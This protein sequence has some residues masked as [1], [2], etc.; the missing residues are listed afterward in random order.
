MNIVIVAGGLG[1][2]FKSLS[3]IPKLLLPLHNEDSIITHDCKIFNN[4]NITVL[5]NSKFYNMFVNYINVNNLTNVNVISTSNCNGSYNTIK[6]VYD[7]LPQNDVLFVWSDLILTNSFQKFDT[8]TNSVFTYDAGKYRYKFTTGKVEQVTDTYDGNVP[9]IYYIKKLDEVFTEKVDANQNYDLIDAIAKVQTS[10]VETKLD[11]VLTEFRDL[12]TY[13]DLMHNS[14]S[15]NTSKTRFF[16]EIK[17]D[18]TDNSM[19]I[20]TAIDD[21]YVNIIQKE[22]GWYNSLK[23]LHMVNNIVPKTDDV[24]LSERSFRMEY[25][26]NYITL[27]EFRKTINDESKIVKVYSTIFNYLDNLS[28]YSIHVSLNTFKEDLKKELVDKVIARCD[29]IKDML[30]NYDKAKMSMLLTKVYTTICDIYKNDKFVTYSFCHGDLN[31]SNIL[32]NAETLDV[33]FID[34]RG[35]FGNTKLY[36]WMQYEYAKLRYSLNGYDDFNV[37]PQVYTVDEPSLNNIVNKQNII[38][39]KLS[40]T[41]LKLLVGV[42]Y[43]ALAGYISQDICKANIAYEYGMKLLEN[44]IF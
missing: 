23:Q 26:Q 29:K 6:S 11:N 15:N 8:S 21:N 4:A 41:Q 20:K 10:F 12:E 24:M 25:L 19:L 22:F 32:I 18:E 16:N 27:N 37:Q 7:K 38:N 44:E 34:P 43:I 17:H 39:D 42:I 5:I 28:K 40:N 13:I 33:K 1:T 30:V 2:R 9:G 14:T 3:V 36:G 35:Y 31:G